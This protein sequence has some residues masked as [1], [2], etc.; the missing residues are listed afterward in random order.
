M[1]VLLVFLPWAYL[2]TSQILL[3]TFAYCISTQVIPHNITHVQDRHFLPVGW[4]CVGILYRYLMEVKSIFA[5]S[6]KHTYRKSPSP[7]E[8]PR[9]VFREQFYDR[10]CIFCAKSCL[11]RQLGK[12]IRKK[13]TLT[14]RRRFSHPQ[15]S[16]WIGIIFTWNDQC[17][18]LWRR[19][20][21]RYTGGHW[22]ACNLKFGPYRRCTTSA[23]S[24]IEVAGIPVAI[25]VDSGAGSPSGLR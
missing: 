4:V 16:C 21:S 6:D 9:D 12:L 17:A 5:F 25:R 1:I 23:T 11:V 13:Q 2:H 3:T 15:S 18:D 20:T 14:P 19:L 8:Y 24:K 22:G 7:C 10:G